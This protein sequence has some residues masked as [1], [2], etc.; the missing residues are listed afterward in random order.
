M[1][2]DSHM[3]FWRFD[4]TQYSWIGA[5]MDVL[6]RDR[7]PDEAW[8]LL[9]SRNIDRCVAVQARMSEQETDFLLGLASGYS[10]IAAVIG[11]VDLCDERLSQRLERWAGSKRLAGFRHILQNDPNAGALVD[12]VAFRR[13]V[14]LLQSRRMIYEVL[15]TADQLSVVT[16]FCRH[17]NNHWLV[18]DHLGK[19][20]IRKRRFDG[21][22]RDVKP[23]AALPHMVCKLS[24]LV[25]EANDARGNFDVDHLR[26]YLDAALD[27]FGAQRLMFGSDWPVCLLAASYERVAEIVEDWSSRLS[28]SDRESIWGDTATRVYGI[29]TAAGANPPL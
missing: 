19:P 15:V 25:T 29:P 1:R 7:L 8:P 21:W 22:L 13:G 12:G 28:P 14:G 17:A 23:I 24:G 10:W 16:D 3:H 18:L 26:D 6:R 9:T 27:L 2:V 20:D 5:Q 11:W 4:P